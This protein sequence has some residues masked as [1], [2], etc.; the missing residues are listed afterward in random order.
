MKQG[1][2]QGIGGFIVVRGQTPGL[3]IGKREPA[4]GLRGIPETEILFE[5]ME[6]PVEMMLVPPSGLRRGFGDLIDAY[7]SQRVGAGTV[8][9]GLAQGAYD[10]VLSLSQRARA[11]RPANRGIPGPA[12]DARRHGNGHRGE[13]G[14]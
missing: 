5:D 14:R 1:N 7:N 2:D 3:V 6:V 12:M 8:A 9:L 10:L 13:P 4:M 11:V